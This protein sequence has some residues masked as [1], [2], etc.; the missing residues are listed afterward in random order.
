MPIL[1]G[2]IATFSALGSSGCVYRLAPPA[3]P[4]QQRLRIIANAPER[5]TVRVQSNDYTVPADGLVVFKMG[6]AQGC[7]VYLFNR[8]PIRGTPSPTKEKS[9]SIM[10][11]ASLVQR[12][13]IRD[14]STLPTDSDG[15]PQFHV[16]GGGRRK[17]GGGR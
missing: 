7:S 2:L 8:I 5:Y 11:G 3:P 13:S 4:F 6:M 14:I 17:R 15:V 16:A 1:S 12:L 9:I 10:I